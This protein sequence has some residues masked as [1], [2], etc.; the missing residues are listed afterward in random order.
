M[1]SV[2]YSTVTGRQTSWL[3]KSRPDREFPVPS[4]NTRQ[5]Y[6]RGSAYYETT[7]LQSIGGEETTCKSQ[8]ERRR[9]LANSAYRGNAGSRTGSD[10]AERGGRDEGMICSTWSSTTQGALRARI[11]ALGLTSYAKH[12]RQLI[13]CF[14]DSKLLNVAT[15][16]TKRCDEAARHIF[17]SQFI[18]ATSSARSVLREAR[19]TFGSN[20]MFL[21]IATDGMDCIKRKRRRTRTASPPARH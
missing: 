7:Q 17:R 11:K 14:Y 6:Q 18:G 5:G 12:G 10:L 8:K 19:F 20:G 9:F 15:S 13:S 21:A 4:R 1:R 3:E 16:L 2:H